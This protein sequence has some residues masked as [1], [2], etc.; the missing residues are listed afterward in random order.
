MALVISSMIYVH[1]CGS[2]IYY[3]FFKRSVILVLQVN[4]NWFAFLN[5]FFFIFAVRCFQLWTIDAWSHHDAFYVFKILYQI[6]ISAYIQ[7]YPQRMRLQRRL[8]GINTVCFLKKPATLKL[9]SFFVKKLNKP[10]KDFKD[11]EDL[12]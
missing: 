2:P 10:F 5:F 7:G 12:I 6:Y 4:S 3:Y 9:L 11:E 8:Y 1:P